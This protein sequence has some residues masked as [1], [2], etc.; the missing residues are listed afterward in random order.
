[1]TPKEKDMWFKYY[2]A[3]S[4]LYRY[5]SVKEQNATETATLEQASEQSDGVTGAP[6]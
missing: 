6:V 3:P 1:M 5:I 4:P 2:F